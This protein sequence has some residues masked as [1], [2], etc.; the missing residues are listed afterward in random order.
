MNDIVVYK[1]KDGRVRVYIKNEKK[2]MSYPKYLLE[3]E[4][5]R[6]LNYNEQVHHKDGNPLNNALSNLEIKTLGEHQREHRCKYHD[7]IA[8]C[9]WC[10]NS[11]LW[12]AK[13]QRSFQSNKSRR[14][15]SSNLNSLFCSKK[16]VGEYGKYIQKKSLN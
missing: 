10:N 8:V 11:F 13:Q 7:K 6:P 12:T 16:C 4:L 2:V 9:G 14:G 5:G 1:C 15:N 3:Q